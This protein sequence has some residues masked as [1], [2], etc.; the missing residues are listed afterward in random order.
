MS[1]VITYIDGF[2]LYFGLKSRGW[3]R[4]YWLDVHALSQRLLR[5][6]Q[7]PVG[8]KYFTSP[9]AA[10]PGDPGKDRRQAAYLEALAI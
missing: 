10:A 7:A 1:R 2:N 3:R 9:V 6:G 4:F 5:P 8:V